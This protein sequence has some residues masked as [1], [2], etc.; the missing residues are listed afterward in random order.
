MGTYH[1]LLSGVIAGTMALTLAVPAAGANGPDNPSGSDSKGSI[2]AT[3][4]LDYGQKRSELTNRKVMMELKQ[5]M[6]V[7][8][9]VALGDG[10]STG[11]L[12]VDYSARNGEGGD[13]GG[14]EWPGYLDVTVSQLP[15]GEYTLEFRGEGYVTYRQPITLKTHSQAVVLGTGDE[16][17]G[18]GDV[19]G[20]NVVDLSD[21]LIMALM[22]GR[23]E[24]DQ[25]ERYDLNGDGKIDITDLAYVSRQCYAKGEAELYQTELIA[26]E[27]DTT[28]LT[29]KLNLTG[30]TAEDLFLDNGVSVKLEPKGGDVLEIPFT[31][32]ETP[33]LESIEIVTPEGMGSIEK[34]TV[35]V[36]DSGGEVKEYPIDHTL[37]ADVFAMSPRGGHDRVVTIDLGSRV[38]VKKVTISVTQAHGGYVV[39]D[40]IRF[41]RDI[42]PENPIAPNHMV[43]NVYAIE[44]DGQVTLKWGELPNVMGYQVLCWPEKGGE[45]QRIE[46][47]TS[48]VVVSGLKNLESYVFTVTPTSTG[49]EGKPSD[50][51]TATPQPA[52]AP[53]APDMVQVKSGDGVLH[54]S[55]KKS[56]TATAYEVYYA[57][58]EKTDMED[59][60]KVG[61]VVTGTQVSI[62][63]LTNGQPCY[64]YVTATNSV[65][66]SEPS[67][68]AV[69]T[70]M[71]V[72]YKEPAGLP[73]DLIRV[74]RDQVASITLRDPS[75]YSAFK[76]TMPFTT[77]YLMDG[78]YRTNWTSQSYGDGSFSRS[79]EIIYT[80]RQP[81]D[82]SHVVYVPRADGYEDSMR[83]YGVTV[84]CRGDD[85][86]GSGT[87]L[88]TMD[89][90]NQTPIRGK[91]GNAQD[92]YFLVLPFPA[93][94]DIVKIAIDIEQTNYGSVGLSEVIFFRYD[95]TKALDVQIEQLFADQAH[96]QLAEG[97]TKDQ[98]QA[99]KTALSGNEGYYFYPDTMKDELKLAEELLTGASSGAVLEGIDSRS[100]AADSEKYGQGGSE[101]QPLGVA[102]EAGQEIAVYA[103]GIPQG[104]TVTLWATQ[105]HAE[106]GAWQASL[107]ALQN[108]RNVV[109]LPEIGN[110][111]APRGGSLY[112]TYSGSGGQGITLH[113]RQA[114]KI[115]VL[116][117]DDWYGLQEEGR[118]ERISA[119]VEELSAYAKTI[120]AGSEK[121]NCLNVTEISMPS[122]LLSLP[123]TVVLE[124][125]GRG[126]TGD[127]VET[128]YRNVIAWEQVM[129]IA[130]TT[131]GIDNTMERNDMTSRQNIR[132][133]QMFAGA[134][135][136]AAGSHIGVEYG[137]CGALVNG[138]PVE[139]QGQGNLF[140]WGIAHEIGH[141]MD[142]LG[143]AEIT[144]NIY[145]LMVQTFDGQ[146]NL[147]IS[148]LE[149][150]GKYGEIFQ[151]VAQGNPGAS[152][153]VFVQ[154]GMYWQLHLAYDGGVGDAHGPMDFYNRFFKAWKEGSRFG[155]D[156]SYDDKVALTASFVAQKDLTDFFTRWGMQLSPSTQRKLADYEK[157]T[158]AIWYLDDNSRRDRLGG[159]SAG[160]G[161]VRA[162]AVLR[163][164]KEVLLTLESSLT[165]GTLQGYEI[166]RD[167]V[168]VGFTAETTFTDQ[169]GSANHRTFVYTVQAYDTMGNPIGGEERAGEIRVAYDQTV[170]PD[171]YQLVRE[172]TTVRVTMRNGAVPV[173]GIKLSG[174]NALSGQGDYTV[175]VTNQGRQVTAKAGNYN[176]ND[177]VDDPA[178]YLAYFNK[179]YAI[180][181]DTRIWTFDTE[182]LVMTNV[183]EGAD[184]A[185][186]RYAGDDVAFAENGAVG[187]LAEE[188]RYGSQ[189]ED[190]IPAGTLVITGT[191]RGD[192]VYNT[193]RVKGDFTSTELGEKGEQ[194][195][196]RTERYLDGYA[197]F[198]AE[199][200]QDGEVSDIS[201]GIFLFVPNTQREQEL[202]GEQS[203]CG[204]ENLL[205][206][207]IMVELYRTD[208]PN[209]ADSMRL[210]AS[211]RWIHSPG[212]ED[213]PKISLKGGSQ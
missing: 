32:T 16:T 11:G 34:G 26:P 93:T 194:E 99:L 173:S 105:Y 74:P 7:L 130:K 171:T 90:L 5:G 73:K 177:A 43:K 198:F 204:Q 22:V 50:P 95:E 21:R 127:Q 59:C 14:G 186:I 79:K 31:L 107:G 182:E 46:T 190:V 67:K 201:D 17:F 87:K 128:L 39:V 69:G 153:D 111:T 169:I 4:R 113:T 61:G 129:H 176:K 168:P 75:N 195:V 146:N 116:E 106:A 82:M 29:G 191:Y 78:D 163:G 205:P 3:L 96:T 58:E 12:Q 151:K 139:A 172:G 158:R 207:R 25:V 120:P 165:D 40:T 55:W 196:R 54:V 10:T 161:T 52:R 209:Q 155:P 81:V 13:L 8:G 108:G 91:M 6:T 47:R 84:W 147:G 1:R 197:L 103:Q 112:I 98:I 149:S 145:A 64:V 141:N 185:L 180:H 166:R 80:F 71:A 53:D 208:D 183:P 137:S 89:G 122:V 36:T 144:N 20:D 65:G 119:Y 132:Y 18:L 187:I 45:P 24:P 51:V 19:N 211:S 38:A 184:L 134:F 56:R 133:M 60:H 92:G 23:Q 193:L 76:S 136:Y 30:G 188:Y 49:W 118:R 210:T 189:T 143:K 181:G 41:L 70:P 33:E 159:E 28:E 37:P 142:K 102:G 203:H 2:R 206:A 94:K 48:T 200:P 202:Q 63:N 150:G 72:E 125:C 124:N 9:R 212:G 160:A 213:L 15:L 162:S 167:G 164:E 123:A 83:L 175:T 97:V 114:V 178:S 104:E 100:S 154:L 135:M 88:V 148:R 170:D 121:D 192:P 44:G 117:L 86:N 77:D 157:E 199:I 42:V 140:G 126:G 109:T 85:L 68:A 179:P 57:H 35:F 174:S 62:P 27:V 110:Q 156:D 138:N 115:P 131:Q 152:N 66:R 101:F